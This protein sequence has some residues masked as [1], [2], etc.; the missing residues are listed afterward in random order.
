M[1]PTTRHAAIAIAFV[2]MV[3]AHQ[4]AAAPT[5]PD[6]PP[7]LEKQG[8][9]P[10]T[11]ITST[12]MPTVTASGGPA[13]VPTPTATKTATSTATAT[14]TRTPTVVATALATP[15]PI[16]TAT[17]TDPCA[18][19]LQSLI[20]ATPRGGT[21]T[22]PARGCIFRETITLSKPIKIFGQSTNELRG[23]DVWT[24]WNGNTSTPSLPPLARKSID[25][26]YNT[27]TCT[28]ITHTSCNQP[29]QVFRDGNWLRFV[30]GSPGSGAWTLDGSG[31]V[32]LGESPSGHLIE[33]ATRRLWATI[34]SNASGVYI[35]GLTFRHSVGTY[36]DYAL[37]IDG[38][39]STL[40]NNSFFQAG[41][42]AVR[43]NG[44]DNK[45]LGNEI[46][47]NG[48]LGLSASI[49]PRF[50]WQGGTAQWN[51]RRASFG[52]A[53]SDY[54]YGW[55]A[56]GSKIVRADHILV[57]GVSAHD[58]GGPGLW[59]D[60][61]CGAVAYTHNQTGQNLWDGILIEGP[62]GPFLVDSNNAHGNTYCGIRVVLNDAHLD[63]QGLV[64]N[65]SASANG[66][67]GICKGYDTSQQ[68]VQSQ[69]NVIYTG[70]V[71]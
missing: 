58:N 67:P 31:H 53:G 68:T 33:V 48:G 10:T 63:A 44:S 64:M 34:P 7:G 27:P 4:A 11:T 69:P 20:D 12:A 32:V 54:W 47:W 6:C 8:R 16:P 40:E 52:A 70:N 56:S 62:L 49:A 50:L 59:C 2:G 30:D 28:D 5:P 25:P 15:V 29:Y 22:L 57:D 71:P 18:A 3:A 35:H 1:S 43:V 46:S 17:P 26:Q 36:Q 38:S 39:G 23:S 51:N 60:I 24:S 14:S 37:M 65:N 45:V 55:E 42:G 41:Y 21:L 13:D 19:S 66:G 61:Q 9:C